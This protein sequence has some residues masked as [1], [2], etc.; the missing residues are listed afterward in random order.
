MLAWFVWHWLLSVRLLGKLRGTEWYF[1][2]AGL[3]GGL[4]VNYAQSVLE[5]VLR[6]P[7]NLIC[8]MFVFAALSYLH[9]DWRLPETKKKAST[10]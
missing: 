7:L 5:W 8:L 4:V 9:A 10:L 6:Q 1:V 2:A 3:C